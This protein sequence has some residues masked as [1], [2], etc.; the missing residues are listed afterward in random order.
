MLFLATVAFLKNERFPFIRS[1]VHS[2]HPSLKAFLAKLLWFNFIISRLLHSRPN[3]KSL[4]KHQTQRILDSHQSWS[5][6]ATCHPQP[7]PRLMFLLH[8][9]T[10]SMVNFL[11]SSSLLKII[12]AMCHHDTHK[13]KY[14][15]H[16]HKYKNTN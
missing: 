3:S 15:A 5:I 10:W 13:D 8:F 11:F 16:I 4:L 12:L 9:L 14:N 7:S 2:I 1:G 6:L